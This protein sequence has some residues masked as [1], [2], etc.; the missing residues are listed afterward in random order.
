MYMSFAAAVFRILYGV[1]HVARFMG[2]SGPTPSNGPFP[3]SPPSPTGLYLWGAG[4]GEPPSP[5]HPTVLVQL[6]GYLYGLW[7]G[8]GGV[9]R[10]T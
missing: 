2:F 3:P 4:E 10:G 9:V 1:L 7:G 6:C 8:G 5:S